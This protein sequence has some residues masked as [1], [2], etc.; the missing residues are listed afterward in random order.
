MVFLIKNVY[1]YANNIFYMYI[2]LLL[3]LLIKKYIKNIFLFYFYAT[4]SN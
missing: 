1:M 2:Y 4:I 3:L